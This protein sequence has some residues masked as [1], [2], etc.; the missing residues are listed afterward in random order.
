MALNSQHK[1]I[2]KNRVSITYD[3]ETNGATETRELPFVVGVIGSFS[4]DRPIEE[5]GP[6][7]ERQF[8]QIDKDNFD[9]VMSRISPCLNLKIPN[10][11]N[12]EGEPLAVSLKFNNMAD[13]LPENIVKQVP[14]L[15]KLLET[16]NNLK[17][18]LSKADRSKN[19]ETLLKE[20][21]QNNDSLKKIADELGI[22]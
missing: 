6:V 3:V 22:N 10:T 18:L 14:E 20:T 21:I 17:I 12:P 2:R 1:R 8:I 4:G 15:N 19:L 13:F 16:R 11:L 9:T 5:K 7:E